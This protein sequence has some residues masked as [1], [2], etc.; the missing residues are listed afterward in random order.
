ML[1]G[2]S[3]KDGDFDLDRV[4]EEMKDGKDNH[5]V[6]LK[7]PISIVIF[8]LTAIVGEDGRVDFFDDIYKY[9]EQ[10]QEVLQKGPPY[11][12]YKEPVKPKT[13]GGYGVTAHL[14]ASLRTGRPSRG[15]R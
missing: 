7:K 11:P 8:Y 14:N 5:Q 13:A 12:E 9:D 4:R 1:Q 15:L 6:N 10:M 3:D 2:Q